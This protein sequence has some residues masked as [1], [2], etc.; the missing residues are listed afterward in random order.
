FRQFVVMKAQP[1]RGAG[2]QVLGQLAAQEAGGVAEHAFGFQTSLFAFTQQSEVDIGPGQ[3][4]RHFHLLDGNQAQARVFHADA[5]Q[6]CQLA[7]DVVPDPVGALTALRTTMLCHYSVRATTRTSNTSILS[8]AL[9]S[10]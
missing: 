6:G 5:D 2:V 9:T 7:L 8:P 4:T 1:G 3:V 10:L